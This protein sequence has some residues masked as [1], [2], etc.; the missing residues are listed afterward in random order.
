MRISVAESRNADTGERST[1]EEG[2]G[3]LPLYRLT[4]GVERC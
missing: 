1:I 3:E 2:G 4:E